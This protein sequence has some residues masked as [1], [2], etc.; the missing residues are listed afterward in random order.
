M[1]AKDPLA[2]LKDIHLPPPVSWWPPAPGWWLL[3]FLFLAGFVAAGYFLW[4]FYHSRAYRRA[5][6]RELQIL[7][8]A[9]GT[10]ERK[11]LEQLAALVRRVAIEGC[12]REQ[13]VG[14]SG[15]PWLGFLD[16][17]GATT[18]FSRGPGRALGEDLYRPGAAA[19]LEKL[20]PL[21]ETWIRRHRQC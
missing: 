2:A 11:R 20:M 5:A 8:Q 3:A 4:R 18:E 6:L 19:D 7:R 12:G 16:R 1:N 17:T 13:V 9:M 10:D 14:L 15:R 21:V